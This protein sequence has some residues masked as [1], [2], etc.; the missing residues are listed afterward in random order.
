MNFLDQITG[1]TQDTN[2]LNVVVMGSRLLL[3]L[4]MGAA[5]AGLY[6]LTHRRDG[7]QGWSFVSTLVLLAIVIAMV[8]QVIGNNVA[9]AFSLVGALSIVRFR[10]IVEDT[11]D[12]AFVILSVVVGMAV[13]L[14][15]LWVAL[16][17]YAVVALACLVMRSRRATANGSAP[18]WDLRVRIGVGNGP[19]ELMGGVFAR[20][21]D[22]LHLCSASSSRQGAA[23]D[24]EYRVRLRPDGDAAAAISELNL[25]DGVQSAELKRD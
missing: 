2:Q 10:T 13:G 20:H 16:I 15:H 1:L 23:L 25:L 19:E 9:R 12:T 5:I 11:R 3:A 6:W 7:S 21:F 8:T 24:L 18:Y 22:A 14:G 4:V 17:G